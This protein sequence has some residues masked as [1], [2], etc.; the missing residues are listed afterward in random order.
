MRVEGLKRLQAKLKTLQEEAR[1]QTLKSVTVGYTAN[2]AL[3]VH[4][5]VEM[6]LKGKK[7]PGK[8]R[9]KF[10]DPQGRA[11]AKFLEEP[12]R[13]MQGELGRVVAEI[14][15]STGNIQAGLL[16]AG[17]RL[18][19]ESQKRCPVDT[20]NLKNTAFTRLE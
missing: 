15:K 3:Y 18:Q 17:L 9:G 14:T 5:K 11:Q 20:G 19:R 12:A 4:E 7:R 13:T 2:Y 6:K 8:N 10:W 16:A 1:R